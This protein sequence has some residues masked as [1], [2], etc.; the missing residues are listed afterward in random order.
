MSSNS[1]FVTLCR[2]LA[3][4]Y[5][6][7]ANTK[8]LNIAL[9]GNEYIDLFTEVH[10]RQWE[11]LILFRF[12]RSNGQ[13]GE[14]MMREMYSRIK[15]LKAGRGICITAGDFSEGARDFVEARLIDLVEK[16]EL[17]KLFSRL[18]GRSPAV[19]S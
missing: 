7:R 15:E 1:E 9:P 11:D 8:I 14:L 6:S 4:S 10:N 16:E 12:I 3:T 2:K 19:V 17:F 5:F 18:P 13:S